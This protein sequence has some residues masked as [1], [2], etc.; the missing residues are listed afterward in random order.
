MRGS[1][2]PKSSTDVWLDGR[3]E[4]LIGLWKVIKGSGP[5]WRITGHPDVITPPVRSEI[6]CASANV[7]YLGSAVMWNV[8]KVTIK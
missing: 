7:V 3:W 8:Q 2:L 4:L 1:D 6:S 5:N